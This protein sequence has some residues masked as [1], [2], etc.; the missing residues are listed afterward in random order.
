M[1]LRQRRQARRRSA[2]NDCRVIANPG[3][4]FF[5]SGV[6][7][8]AALSVGIAMAGCGSSAAGRDGVQTLLV[9]LPRALSAAHSF[10][11]AIDG[12]G[13]DDGRAPYT[14]HGTGV[15][16]WTA[17][18]ANLQVTDGRQAGQLIIV[19][20][21]MYVPRTTAAGGGGPT[22]LRVPAGDQ[23]ALGGLLDLVGDPL[24][25]LSSLRDRLVGVTSEGRTSVGGV[26]TTE[27]SGRLRT[28]GPGVVGTITVWIDQQ[29]RIRQLHLTGN[30]GG[31]STD[32]TEQFSDF[33]VAVHVV[34][35]PA[36]EVT[37]LQR[38][39]PQHSNGLDQSLPQQQT[40]RG[41]LA[42]P[43]PTRLKVASTILNTLRRADNRRPASDPLRSEFT[44]AAV[45]ACTRRPSQSWGLVIAQL[46][47]NKQRTFDR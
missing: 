45:G 21:T 8:F 38:P 39:V 28:W 2:S 30:G 18:S 37:A 16:D 17:N 40:C 15:V 7:C 11:I 6:R 24:T 44:H 31:L 13:H 35:P 5:R 34:A 32:I 1:A 14:F 42:F 19:R 29:G 36:N 33:G 46:Y 3:R 4:R 10:R 12:T 26:L 27:L 23:R 41:F 20:G 43:T 22:W 47:S 25:T 9:G